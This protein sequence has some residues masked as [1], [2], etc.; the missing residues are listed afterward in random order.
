MLGNEPAKDSARTG[1]APTR[2]LFG[3]SRAWSIRR[4]HGRPGPSHSAVSSSVSCSRH[5]YQARWL[6]KRSTGRSW[7]A[8]YYL[9]K[10]TNTHHRHGWMVI[11][12]VFGRQP[13]TRSGAGRSHPAPRPTTPTAWSATSLRSGTSPVP[14]NLTLRTI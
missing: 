2:S 10:M 4:L 13:T 14:C 5:R 6:S 9:G 8:R 1:M 11:N 7:A 3:V 12:A